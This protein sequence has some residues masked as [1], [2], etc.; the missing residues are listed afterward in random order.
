[1]SVFRYRSDPFDSVMRLQRALEQSL[2]QPFFGL[3]WT[4]G[5][6]G[7]YPAINFFEHGDAVVIK[8]EAAGLDRK[9]I[10][11]RLE[12]NR[13]TV[14]GERKLPPLDKGCSYHRRE[15]KGG[16]FRRTFRLPFE[17]DPDLVRATYADGILEVRMEKA[18]A[19]KPRQIQVQG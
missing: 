8:A 3:D 2:S 1:M 5:G 17:V 16:Q 14:A 12:H 15:R 4:P 9:S 10:D 11:L 13:L 7:L 6:G 18:E 19:A